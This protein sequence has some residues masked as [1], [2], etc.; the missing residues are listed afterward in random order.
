M[1]DSFWKLLTSITLP[2]GERRGKDIYPET[3]LTYL[4]SFPFDSLIS[5]LLNTE[6]ECAQFHVY[7]TS[8]SVLKASLLS[9]QHLVQLV[10][11]REGLIQRRS[12]KMLRWLLV[13]SDDSSWPLLSYGDSFP[14]FFSPVFW[15]KIALQRKSCCDCVLCWTMSNLFQPSYCLSL[16]FNIPLF[17]LP[18][19]SMTASPIYHTL[20]LIFL[21]PSTVPSRIAVSPSISGARF[22][23][24]P[25]I[26][27]QNAEFGLACLA[28]SLS[29]LNFILKNCFFH[30]IYNKVDG[31]NGWVESNVHKDQTETVICHHRK[32]CLLH[33]EALSLACWSSQNMQKPMLQHSS[34]SFQ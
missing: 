17:F 33:S 26:F 32:P 24:Y 13:C 15:R 1:N 28:T 12:Y 8:V 16:F 14:L 9:F 20:S 34:G 21:S 19:F 31:Y 23:Y 22:F 30:D 18:L 5:L 10:C 27:V 6:W 29:L 2:E 4:C 7:T 25:F 3:A 11:N